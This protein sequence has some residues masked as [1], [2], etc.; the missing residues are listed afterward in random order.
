MDESINDPSLLNSQLKLTVVI[1]N[2]FFIYL[3]PFSCKKNSNLACR[4]LF[5]LTLFL[6]TLVVQQTQQ[7]TRRRSCFDMFKEVLVNFIL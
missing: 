6:I 5:F 3:F 2:V 4:L 1:M 7:V